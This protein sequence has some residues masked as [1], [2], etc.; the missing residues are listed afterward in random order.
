[1]NLSK[2]ILIVIFLMLLILIFFALTGIDVRKPEQAAITLIEK[3]VD[4]NRAI[5]RA[6]RNFFYS[7]RT[8]FNERFSR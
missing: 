7:I 5:N 4:L 3:L 1:M 2:A 8:S 6:I